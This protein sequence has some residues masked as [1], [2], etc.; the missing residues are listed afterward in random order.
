MITNGV[1]LLTL[2][3]MQKNMPQKWVLGV[4]G[5]SEEYVFYILCLFK[6]TYWLVPVTITVLLWAERSDYKWTFSVHTVFHEKT[7]F[8]KSALCFQQCHE[9]IS[10]QV[11]NR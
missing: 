2:F 5:L 10:V 8:R 1:S 11:E 9:D 4:V 6:C 7:S 3:I